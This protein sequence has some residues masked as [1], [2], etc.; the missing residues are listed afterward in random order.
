MKRTRRIEITQY[1]R[2]VTQSHRHKHATGR[3]EEMTVIETAV[4]EWH[5][6]PEENDLDGA[7][8]VTTLVPTV[9]TELKLTRTPFNFRK[10]LRQKF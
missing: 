5:I 9:P 8:L 7:R 3:T 1:R 2:T 4:N 6:P 10:W